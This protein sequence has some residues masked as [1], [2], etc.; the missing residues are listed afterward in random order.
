MR[1]LSAAVFA[2]ALA[3]CPLAYAQTVKVNWNSRAQF[4]KYK[5]YSRK[6]AANPGNP[7]FAQWV[8]PDVDAKLAATGL[9][10]LYPGQSPDLYVIYSVQTVEKE[11]ATTTMEAT[12]GVTA[13]GSATVGTK[14]WPR[15]CPRVQT[16]T[17]D[18]RQ[19]LGIL[20]IDIVDR[21][22]KIVIWRGQSTIEHVSKND[23]RDADQFKKSSTRCSRS[24]HP[25]DHLATPCAAIEK[26]PK[27]LEQQPSQ[28]Q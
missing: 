28:K 26:R 9:Q 8:Q 25:A 5:T 15:A 2:L 20:T 4:S 19:T 27:E 7:L 23:R 22:K 21:A 18:S 1:P 17:T 10:F 24:F 14:R 3:L 13:P 11:D 16:V 6:L 12:A